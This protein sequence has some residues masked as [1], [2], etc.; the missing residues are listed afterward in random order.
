MWSEKYRPWCQGSNVLCIQPKDD[1]PSQAMACSSCSSQYTLQCSPNGRIITRGLSICSETKRT[2]CDGVR[3]HSLASRSHSLRNVMKVAMSYHLRQYLLGL[4]TYFACDGDKAKPGP[5]RCNLDKHLLSEALAE[6]HAGV[7]GHAS[8]T[9]QPRH[10]Y[11]HLSSLY[12]KSINCMYQKCGRCWYLNFDIP[13]RPFANCVSCSESSQIALT[14]L[15]S[16]E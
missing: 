10:L 16:P 7:Q 2:P 8:S 3:A 5:G 12:R 13:W 15:F 6:G 4:T 11:L 1:Q 9:I 14:V